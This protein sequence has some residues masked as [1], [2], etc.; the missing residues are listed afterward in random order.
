MKHRSNWMS[1]LLDKV[2]YLAAIKDAA[3]NNF[4]KVPFT[5]DKKHPFDCIVYNLRQMISACTPVPMPKSVKGMIQFSLNLYF[6]VFNVIICFS[7]ALKNKQALF[8]LACLFHMFSLSAQTPR[9]DSGAEGLLSISGTVVSS[10]DEKP[11]QGV[12]IQVQGE[13]GRASSKNDGSF[14]LAVS[15]S[16][17]TVEFSHMGFR[18]LELPYVAGVSLNV[19]LIPIENQLDEVEVVSTGYQ[20]IPKERA[21]GSF[22]FVDNEKINLTKGRNIL[23]RLDGLTA[24]MFFDKRMETPTVAQQ[25]A[26]RTR[27]THTGKAYPLIVLDNFPYEGD[28]ENIDPNDIEN[29]TIL[30]DAA[31]A[32]IWGS[33][34]GNGV[35]VLTS[36]KGSKAGKTRVSFDSNVQ[37]VQK[38]DLYYKPVLSSRSFIEMEE[39]LY[40]NGYYDWQIAYPDIVISP[41]VDMLDKLKQ[42]L[43]DSLTYKNRVNEF[44]EQDVRKDYLKYVYRVGVNQQYSANIS[45]GSDFMDFI[46]SV[47][48]NKTLNSLKTS[49]YERINARIGINYRPTKSL[50]ISFGSQYGNNKNT[51]VGYESPIAYGTL[52][53]GNGKSFFPYLRLVD[54]HGNF[55]DLETTTIRSSFMD[56]LFDGKLLRARYNLGNEMQASQNVDK[57]TD[58]LLNF[59]ARYKLSSALAAQVN[60]QYQNSFNNGTNWQGANSYA[61]QFQIN[62]FSQYK[63]GVLDRKI[64]LGDIY[65]FFNGRTRANNVRGSLAYD[66][67]WSDG[68]HQVSGIIGAEL[69]DWNKRI[70]GSRFYGYD[71]Y[72]LGYVPVNA[73][74]EFPL[75]NGTQGT[76]KIYDLKQVEEYNE[77]LVSVFANA[78]YTY[79]K[80]YTVSASFRKDASNIF[81]I[82]SND[83]WQPLWSSGFLWNIDKEGFYKVDFL[84]SLKIRATYGFNGKAVIDYPAYATMEYVEPNTVT[85]LMYAYMINPPNPNFRAE[86]VGI[87]NVAIDFAFK[88]NRFSGTLEYYTKNGKDIVARNMVDPTVGFDNVVQNSANYFGRG[89]EV[90]LATV[91]IKRRQFSWSTNWMFSYKRNIAKKFNNKPSSVLS[92]MGEGI[93]TTP[94]EG[95]DLYAIFAL[96]FAGLDHNTG[97]PIGWLNGE[98]S[99]DYLSLTTV[100]V[101]QARVMG[102][103]LPIYAGFVRNTWTFKNLTLSAN[104][105][106]KFKFFFRRNSVE[107]VGFANYWSGNS[108]Y[109]QRWQKPGDELTTDVPAF[110]YPMDPT[111]QDFYRYSD[112][113]IEPGDQI[114]LKDINLSYNLDRLSSK[115]K[116]ASLYFNLDNL[117]LILWKKTKYPVDSDFVYNIPS[118]KTYTLGVNLIF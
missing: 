23:S 28:L 84:S 116:N 76:G 29:I 56:T 12:S 19:K 13:K 10:S 93:V 14:S 44:A 107:Y 104:L 58:L 83:K 92:Y 114:K 33:L 51:N 54:D 27:S 74:E 95:K 49:S 53:S 118:P 73:T 16:K 62:M 105:Q 37:L 75:L 67:G 42:D 96:P 111:K 115:L 4:K 109:D 79:D 15:N 35:I 71:K 100:P 113:L 86:R 90:N 32:S 5:W 110:T 91:N 31:A 78:S 85:G 34:A 94:L 59:G 8:M 57:T 64:P 112:V 17:G 70:E 87:F 11:I 1:A 39:M 26:L 21:T 63:N 52:Y 24:S 61:N 41:V 99:M 25:L 106:Y 38:P 102:S 46:S 101:N 43:I 7:K 22:E 88:S 66:E 3:N 65:S 2:A 81:G 77:R 9:K 72:T 18:R 97:E 45:G 6:L 103:A 30:K 89:I 60:Y 55:R 50:E 80:R 68:K 82:A 47:G 48:Y 20:K 36:K 117:N 108:D 40:N 69:K 98:K